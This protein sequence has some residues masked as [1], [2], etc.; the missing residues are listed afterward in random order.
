MMPCIV[1]GK[2]N[3]LLFLIPTPLPQL[4]FLYFHLPS[5]FARTCGK[6]ISHSVDG[7]AEKGVLFSAILGSSA[8]PVEVYDT[9]SG[10]F[11]LSVP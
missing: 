6:C 8:T 5:Y 9:I 11:L 10:F 3:V 1:T 7:V 4:L 2:E